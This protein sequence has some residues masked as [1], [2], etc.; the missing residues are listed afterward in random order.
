RPFVVLVTL[1]A[2][3]RTHGTVYFPSFKV[4]AVV[5]GLPDSTSPAALA[6]A[7][8][9]WSNGVK[10]A[11]VIAPVSMSLRTGGSA[12][13]PDKKTLPA[14]FC[15]FNAST[16]PYAI[17]SFEQTTAATLLLCAV[18]AFSTCFCASDDDHAAL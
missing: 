2:L 11:M 12:S 14:R 3:M 6:A 8:P 10:L 9:I 7:T 13:S 15:A 17:V 4:C 18:S 16:Q 5:T 1:I